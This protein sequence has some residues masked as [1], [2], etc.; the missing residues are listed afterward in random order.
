MPA[1]LYPVYSNKTNDIDF[2]Y[3]KTDENIFVFNKQTNKRTIDNLIKDTTIV[4]FGGHSILERL[5]SLKI[6]Q[7]KNVF[8]DLQHYF[9]NLNTNKTNISLEE[10]YNEIFLKETLSSK[11]QTKD[12]EIK[13]DDILF[14]VQIET[15]LLNFNEYK[16]LD[17][18]DQIAIV[19][20]KI[21][22]VMIILYNFIESR[23]KK[24]A[25]EID[26]ELCQSLIKIEQTGV[27]LDINYL[28]AIKNEINLKLNDILTNIYAIS[29]KKFNINSQREINYVL[30]ELGLSTNKISRIDL[31][32]NYNNTGIL[33]FKYI[34]QYRRLNVCLEQYIKPLY[35]KAIKDGFGR[36]KYNACKVP[37]LTEGHFCFEKTKG[38]I[39]ISEIEKNDEIWTEYGFKHV[40]RAERHKTNK[41]IQVCFS[42]G[43]TICGSPNHPILINDSKQSYDNIYSIERKWCSLEHLFVGE[44]VICNYNY[45]C[46]NQISKT[47]I[48]QIGHL[49]CGLINNYADNEQ[50]EKEFLKLSNIRFSK[51]ISFL[52]FKSYLEF[53]GLKAWCLCLNKAYETYDFV[54]Y[55]E[56]SL[57]FLITYFK[58]FLNE[59]IIN[60][61]KEILKNN[62]TYE[63]KHKN[64]HGYFNSSYEETM[65]VSI[66]TINK[67]EYVY[68][69]EVEDVHQYNAN[70]IVNH[71][72]GRLSSLRGGTDKNEYF[73][74]ISI[75]SVPKSDIEGINI[76]RAFLPNNKCYWCCI[77][78]KAQEMRLASL[79][80]NISF[81]KN[82]PLNKDIYESM[83]NVFHIFDKTEMNFDSKRK[84]IKTISLGMIYGLTNMGIQRQLKNHNIET[85]D[86]IDYR[87]EFFK[88][89]P[90]LKIGQKR[91]LDYAHSINGIYTLSGRFRE[92]NFN[93]RDKTE[94]F[95]RNNR[96]ALNT[97]I[98][99]TCGDIIRKVV[100]SIENKIYPLYKDTGFCLINTIHDEIN[101]SLPKDETLFN[102][103]L[104]DLCKIVKTPFEQRKDICFGYSIAIGENWDCLDK[105][106]F[107]TISGEHTPFMG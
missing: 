27:R 35:E 29:K 72:T 11:E 30:K 99:G 103:I 104:N 79:L 63:K 92:I 78:Y 88:I 102:T 44:H 64:A 8:V 22:N 61:I 53:F 28:S 55:E 37:C 23:D 77:D 66:S 43:V 42:N 39:D 19:I 97:V 73:A 76:R 87:E 89:F 31:Y 95:T 32:D 68:D 67:D 69:I 62:F 70:G 80:Y 60:H 56:N 12:K 49:I 16:T 85:N 2:V 45:D 81:I 7:Q 20:E 24:Y 10:C 90:E 75:Q 46:L 36:F 71:N 106:E 6:S 54:L 58:N 74:N 84:A 40:V 21:F 18:E 41:I 50:N 96:I 52:K 59:R 93:E 51:K 86:N 33:I 94:F 17:K 13:L 9:W 5:F 48:E 15:Y 101:I 38:I 105:K 3:C 107:L 14:K 47:Q 100:N 57:K 4:F 83:N 91:T 25:D 1:F 26:D 82:I 34:D 98:Q 65:V